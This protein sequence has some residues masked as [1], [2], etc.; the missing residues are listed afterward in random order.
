MSDSSIHKA[1]S[2]WRLAA[3]L[4]AAL[5][6]AQM[7]LFCVI[8]IRTSFI[9]ASQSDWALILGFSITGV[10]AAV[11]TSRTVPRPGR[12]HSR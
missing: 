6:L 10:T 12:N 8:I 5:T 3:W 11:C 9:S 2:Q 4:C 1:T 7:T